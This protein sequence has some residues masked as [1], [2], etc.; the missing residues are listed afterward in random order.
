MFFGFEIA[1]QVLENLLENSLPYMKYSYKKYKT[2][3]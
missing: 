1:I 2:I 3:R